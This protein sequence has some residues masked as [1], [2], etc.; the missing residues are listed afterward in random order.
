MTEHKN[1]EHNWLVVALCNG[2]MKVAFA[3][4]AENIAKK[5]AEELALGSAEK[6]DLS[7]S[8]LERV[9]AVFV[10]ERKGSVRSEKIAKWA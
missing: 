4:Q 9:E 6:S 7:E 3:E 2:W 1:D 5:K 10:Y 8:D